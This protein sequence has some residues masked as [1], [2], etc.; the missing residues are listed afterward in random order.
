M[1][2]PVLRFSLIWK[3][4]LSWLPLCR[5]SLASMWLCCCLITIITP[6]PSSVWL[7]FSDDMTTNHTSKTKIVMKPLPSTSSGPF[8]QENGNFWTT[9]STLLLVVFSKSHQ[10]QWLL[11]DM[12]YFLVSF[13]LIFFPACFIELF[14][15]TALFS[16]C[17]FYYYLVAFPSSVSCRLT[18]KAAF[19]LSVTTSP[20]HH[21]CLTLTLALIFSQLPHP[22]CW[23][24]RLPLEAPPVASGLLCLLGSWC[25]PGSHVYVVTLFVSWR[26]CSRGLSQ[27]RCDTVVI[28]QLLQDYHSSCTFFPPSFC[29]SNFPDTQ[30]T[31]WFYKA[32]FSFCFSAS[33][34]VTS[35]FSLFSFLTPLT[36]FS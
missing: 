8:P 1:N 30:H 15:D 18:E 14:L 31:D 17:F 3:I 24:P 29:G 12:I 20:L 6:T 13:C 7:F 32:G 10:S 36:G 19:L 33:T 16:A 11:Q 21:Q 34:T 5:L 28:W 25:S 22:E 2:H 9:A 27:P 35:G 23:M 4:E 26:S